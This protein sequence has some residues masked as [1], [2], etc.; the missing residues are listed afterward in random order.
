MLKSVGAK[1]GSRMVSSVLLKDYRNAAVVLFDLVEDPK[2]K[3]DPR[4]T[5]AVYFLA[6]SLFQDGNG[7]AARIYFKRLVEAGSS[8]HLTP[9]ILRLIEIAGGRASLMRWAKRS[10]PINRRAAVASH[11]KS[12]ISMENHLIH[13]GDYAGAIERLKRSLRVHFSTTQPTPRGGACGA[14]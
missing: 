2:L 5:D 7:S 8:R 14:G 1:R 4:Y 9:S 10:P 13:G 11:R 12:T 6:E 3:G